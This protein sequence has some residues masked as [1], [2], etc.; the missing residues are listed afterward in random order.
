MVTIERSLLRKV[1]R[2]IKGDFYYGDLLRAPGT[3]G[4]EHEGK[5][6]EL[7]YLLEQA[8]GEN[9]RA[10]RSSEPGL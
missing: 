5:D 6:V 8:L 4:T 2:R 3:V 10:Y 7:V 9:V 1:I